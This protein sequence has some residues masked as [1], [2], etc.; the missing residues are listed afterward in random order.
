MPTEKQNKQ[1]NKKLMLFG[2][3]EIDSLS[4]F[5]NAV[6]TVPSLLSDGVVRF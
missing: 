3:R 5:K 4:S 1:T 2:I 6:C